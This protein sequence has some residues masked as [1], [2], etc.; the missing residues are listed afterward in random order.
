M[1]HWKWALVIKKIISSYRI[2]EHN[3]IA[4]QNRKL[5][6]SFK[7]D[8]LQL[9]WLSLKSSVQ[10]REVKFPR[11]RLG[12]IYLAREKKA[13]QEVQDMQNH[14]VIRETVKSSNGC[15]NVS[16]INQRFKRNS[17]AKRNLVKLRQLLKEKLKIKKQIKRRQYRPHRDQTKNKRYQIKTKIKLSAQWAIKPINQMFKKVWF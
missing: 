4:Y 7:L 11:R 15:K 8:L 3:N 5:Q 14:E 1:D 10:R 12:R 9:M 16:N 13:N 17:T 6:S 2:I